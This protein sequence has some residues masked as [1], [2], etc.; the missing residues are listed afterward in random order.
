MVGKEEK[1]GC[2]VS[3]TTNMAGDVLPLQCI[4]KGTGAT[5]KTLPQ[6]E[7]AKAA[8]ALGFLLISTP[9]QWQT[10]ESLKAWFDKVR[11]K[12]SKTAVS[13][14]LTL[15]QFVICCIRL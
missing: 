5:T 9:T 2:T 14:F 8:Q 10:V 12:G 13:G 15:Q 6:R 11:F 4:Y 3:I 7:G 1:R